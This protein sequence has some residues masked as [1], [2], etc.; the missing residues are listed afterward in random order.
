MPVNTFSTG[1]DVTLS[2]V[3]SVGPVNFNLIT[4]FSSKQDTKDVKVTGIDGNTR[5]VRF[6]DGWSG[7]FSLDRQNSVVDDYF[8]QIEAAYYNGAGETPC[9]ITETIAE[10]SGAVT[11]Y[12]YTGVLLKLDDA[13]TWTGEDTV[14]QTIS[15][16]CAKR[17][18][19]A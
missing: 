18:K 9:S 14:K 17:L 6:P 1:R 10:A 8:A 11:Q 5:Y 13:G 4:K 15:F 2:V 16:V 12:R 7:S 19:I 3:T